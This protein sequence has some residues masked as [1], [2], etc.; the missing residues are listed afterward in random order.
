MRRGIKFST[1]AYI[2]LALTGLFNLL[3]IV[4][5]QLVVQQ[6]DK[7]RKFDQTISSKKQE[8]YSNLNSHKIFNELYITVHFRSSDLITELNYLTKA[9]NFLNGN[10]PKKIEQSKIEKIKPT[11]I[12]KIKKIS[13]NFKITVKESNLIFKKV[14][15]DKMFL[16]FLE[17]ERSIHD[18]WNP[19]D[20][21]EQLE[22]DFQELLDK[23]K[24]KYL[25]NYNFNAAT[26]KEQLANYSL[27][28]KIYDDIHDFNFLKHSID[29]L[30]ES[31]REEYNKN[32]STYY[33]LLDEFAELNNLKNY[34][35]LLSILFQIIALVT[36]VI[37]FRVLIIEN[38]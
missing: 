18:Y 20:P 4:F 25:S 16:K 10:M 37:L 28:T 15:Q 36:L 11:Y 6:Q 30:S 1:Q 22:K 31:F 23:T 26:S 14:Q 27:Y 8:V 17:K 3:S 33:L 35:I 24:Y 9:L 2:F 21:L 7:I 13:N 12:E 38:K 32:F 34:L 19:T 29:D 5:D